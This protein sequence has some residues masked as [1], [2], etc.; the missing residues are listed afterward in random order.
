MTPNGRNEE[1]G[2]K[3]ARAQSS[4]ESVRGVGTVDGVTVEVSADNTICSIHGP[5][6][7]DPNIVLDAYRIALCDKQ[8]RVDSAMREVL[9]DERITQISTFTDV[10][11]RPEPEEQVWE[12][13]RQDPLGRSRGRC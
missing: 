12:Q 10:H 8:P 1:L 9:E 13:I 6:S 4:L 11:C 3:V 5:P 7:V 2:A